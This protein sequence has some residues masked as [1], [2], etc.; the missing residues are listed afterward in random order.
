M[1]D[2]C[3]SQYPPAHRSPTSRGHA[4]AEL[5]P[6]VSRPP[7]RYE[8]VKLDHAYESIFHDFVCLRMAYLVLEFHQA[9]QSTVL[10]YTQ[11]LQNMKVVANVNLFMSKVWDKY[12]DND[13][14]SFPCSYWPSHFRCFSFLSRRYKQQQ[15]R[16]SNN[17]NHLLKASHLCHSTKCVTPSHMCLETGGQNCCRKECARK[18]S[19]FCSYACRRVNPFVRCLLQ[20]T[21]GSREKQVQ[22]IVTWDRAL[23]RFAFCRCCREELRPL[24]QL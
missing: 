23:R 3:A 12:R 7:T 14:D 17:A 11:F 15:P 6:R 24:L 22:S 16:P 1:A 18:S 5:Y 8:I 10:S 2:S 9:V 13:A 4:R 20:K 19:R 21:M